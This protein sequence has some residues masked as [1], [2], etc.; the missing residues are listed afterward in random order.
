MFF[1]SYS[2]FS[3]VFMYL[4]PLGFTLLSK[5]A[6]AVPVRGPDLLAS[7]DPITPDCALIRYVL[8]QLGQPTQPATISHF[9]GLAHSLF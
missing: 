7:D 8:L 6:N 1:L 5:L 3:N 2:G 9:S 4:P